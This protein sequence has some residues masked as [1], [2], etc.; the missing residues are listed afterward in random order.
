M[1]MSNAAQEHIDRLLHFLRDP[2]SYWHHPESVEIVQTHASIVALCPPYVVK[3]KK[4]VNFQFLDYST[5]EKRR[6]FCYQEVLKN[7][8]LCPGTYLNVLPIYE[9][10]TGAL[11]FEKG[12]SVVEYAVLMLY[13]DTAG[14]YS[15]FCIE[16]R[17]RKWHLEFLA[18]RLAQ[19]YSQQEFDPQIGEW[20][21]P[22]KLRI[23]TDENIT[24]TQQFV[25]TLISETA[26]NILV[27]YTESWYNQGAALFAERIAKG[28][29]RNCHGDLRLEHIH[30]CGD[31]LCI[32]DCIEFN[33][34]LRW[35]DIANDVAFLVMDLLY[36][37]APHSAFAFVDSMRHYLNDEKL[38][39]IL[40]FYVVY[41]AWVR[42]KVAALESVLPEVSEQQQVEARSRARRFFRI[43]LRTALFG[44]QPVVV[45]VFGKIGSGK[46]TFAEALSAELGWHH[47]ST[48]AV[49]KMM[50]GIP[51]Q[52]FPPAEVRK[53]LYQPL[54]SRKVYQHLLRFALHYG[55]AYENGAIVEGTFS[56]FVF[57]QQAREY[58]Q[59]RGVHPVFV[60]LHAPEEQII[61]RLQQ[62]EQHNSISDARIAEYY[63]LSPSFEEPLPEETDV[64]ALSTTAPLEQ[65][66]DQF[67]HHCLT[68]Y[69]ATLRNAVDTDAMMPRI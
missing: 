34:R 29:I 65:T 37:Q 66:L 38:E 56:K 4:P 12:H 18:R 48:D 7:R 16:N 11:S 17:L 13:L 31:Q 57:R 33:D 69:F 22:Q 27:Q 28:W 25:G 1:V 24:Q 19:Y 10:P 55:V 35:I 30:L 46:S 61:T 26:Y 68:L 6:F 23:S 5:L 14:L 20:A 59:R 63:L 15:T 47:F 67:F 36:Y 40:P 9:T 54:V 39:L 45:I 32:Y 52:E 8:K 58:F 42:A 41:R 2:K 44:L 51:P 64:I 21:T 60:Y 53:V 50:R 3:V 62:R 43:A 49:R